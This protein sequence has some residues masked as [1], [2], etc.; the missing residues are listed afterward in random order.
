MR[1]FN[2]IL[3][4]MIIFIC[5]VG[6]N[7]RLG[8]TS[9]EKARAAKDEAQSQGA[10]H[11]KTPPIQEQKIALPPFFRL[12]SNGSKVWVERILVT[13]TMALPKNHLEYDFD[14]PTFRNMF[15]DLFQL[16]ELETN[17]QAQAVAELKRQVGMNV[18]P[19]VEISRSVLIMR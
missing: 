9:N 16:G 1:S 7:T 2:Y 5:S 6:F 18:K 13:F 10:I 3:I 11:D 15:Y 14:N 4:C 8:A 19:A 12:Q 17:I